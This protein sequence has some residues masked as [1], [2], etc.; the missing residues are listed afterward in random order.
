MT[1]PRTGKAARKSRETDIEVELTLDGQGRADVKTGVGFFDHMLTA[2][3]L[4]ARF[5]L[6]V[7]ATGDLHIS[8]HHT[9]ED[10][11]IVVGQALLAAL[12]DRGGIRRYGL[13]IMPMDEALVRTAVDI[14]GRAYVHVDFGWRE[15]FGPTGFDYPLAG[16]FLW[17][18]ARAAHL[19]IH[20][21]RLHGTMNHHICE[22]AFKG[23]GRALDEATSLDPRLAGAAP[24]TKGAL[25]GQ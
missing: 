3:A 16:E 11:G 7:R 2:F 13:S 18:L 23:F 8:Q 20:V 22:A 21:D 14:S 25:D 19:T 24:S 15:N 12:G 6:K 17:A 9:V 4:N 1:L 5:D 10:V